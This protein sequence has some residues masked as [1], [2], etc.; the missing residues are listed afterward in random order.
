MISNDGFFF[1]FLL[2]K[3]CNA[4][5]HEFLVAWTLSTTYILETLSS[6]VFVTLCF[7]HPPPYSI[8][9]HVQSHLLTFLPI[10]TLR[11]CFLSSLF[12]QQP[13]PDTVLCASSLA[14]IYI[15]KLLEEKKCIIVVQITWYLGS[16]Q[17]SI[18]CKPCKLGKNNFNVCV[19]VISINLKFTICEMRLITAYL[20]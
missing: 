14:S 8:S 18:T 2:G 12:W 6:C 20:F 16:N 19:C 5:L 3:L 17:N 15:N 7:S 9:D 11:L 13:L 1:F 4:C 10:I